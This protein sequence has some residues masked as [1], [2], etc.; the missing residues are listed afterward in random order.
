MRIVFF[1]LIICIL[2][3]CKKE[4]NSPNRQA[5]F[6]AGYINLHQGKYFI[7]IPEVYELAFIILALKDENSISYFVEKRT[8]Y[9]QKV[10]KQFN[11]YKIHKIFS[12]LNFDYNSLMNYYS[13]SN[14]SYEYGFVNHNIVSNKIYSILWAPDI[15]TNKVS[16]IQ[17]FANNSDFESFYLSNNSYYI[18]QINLYDSLVPVKKMWTWLERQFDSRINSYKIVISPLTDG[19]NNSI[20]LSN[21]NFTEALMFVPGY[22]TK[23]QSSDSLYLLKLICFLFTEIDNNYTIPVLNKMT[24]EINQSM[25]NMEKWKSND[26]FSSGYSSATDVLNE[27]FTWSLFCLYAKDNLTNLDFLNMRSFVETNTT[28]RGFKLF[29]LFDQEVIDLYNNKTVDKKVQDL[30]PEILEWVKGLDEE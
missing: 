7:E 22:H 28:N 24:S 27:Y 17:D 16:L 19:S 3:S 29:N 30:V 14:N 21:N 12:Q 23:L 4:N 26:N 25:K 10:I 5:N 13:F 8:D 6:N 15:F 11:S 18:N 1:I 20:T 9:F 2:F